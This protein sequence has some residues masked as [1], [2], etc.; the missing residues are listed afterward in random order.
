MLR[1]NSSLS[2]IS[3][4]A[5]SSPDDIDE[6]DWT[7]EELSAVETA[8][9]TIHDQA[10]RMGT[11][12]VGPPPS[13]LTHNVARALCRQDGWRHTLRATR[14]KI[15]ECG[16]C[17]LSPH[18]GHPDL[19]STVKD[20]LQWQMDIEATPMQ[21]DP[22]ATPRRSKRLQRQCSVDV[23]P[24]RRDGNTLAR[25]VCPSASIASAR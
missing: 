6:L 11:P 22:D 1:R 21:G 8:Y 16:A 7:A 18:S 23:L 4:L 14:A 3:S 15:L 9:N 24:A 20:N 13:Q 25:C 19:E 17:H 10:E 12:F 2:S 5:S